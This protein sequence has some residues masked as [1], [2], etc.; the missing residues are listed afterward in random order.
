MKSIFASIIVLTASVAA[1]AQ[2]PMIPTLQVCNGTS[3]NGGGTVHLTARKDIANSGDF[4]I[5]LEVKCDP[6]GNGFPGGVVAMGFSLSDSSIKD[7]KSLTIEQMTTTGK[8]TPTMYLNGRC[9]ANG[10]TIPCHYW[11]LLSDN[12]QAA[13]TSGTPDIVSVLVVD[14][15]GHRLT[16]GTGP[17]KGDITIAGTGN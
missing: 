8:H 15:T 2:V 17:L 9:T 10:G 3:A 1:F 16:Y 7:M 5:K 4:E 6:A 11:L 13:N 14:K 12:R